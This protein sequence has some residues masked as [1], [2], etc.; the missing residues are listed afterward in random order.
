MSAIIA[1]QGLLASEGEDEVS[2]YRYVPADFITGR[3]CSQKT[4]EGN[5]A[6]VRF[7]RV[8]GAASPFH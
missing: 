8:Q 5:D 1:D 6:C 4:A 3:R 2:Y 7:N